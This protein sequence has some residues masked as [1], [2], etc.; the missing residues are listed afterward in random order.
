VSTTIPRSQLEDPNYPSHERNPSRI[1]FARH[2]SI[3][4]CQHSSQDHGW[5]VPTIPVTNAT[6]AA[7]FRKGPLFLISSRSSANQA[8]Q[9]LF[10][11]LFV[12]LFLFLFRFLFV[13]LFLFLFL[14]SPYSQQ[15]VHWCLCFFLR[16]GGCIWTRRGFCRLR[17][18]FL[19][20]L[21][22]TKIRLGIAL[23][24]AGH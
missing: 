8:L 22:R 17:S 3:C 5:K 21:P 20:D 4:N 7:C 10:R 12:L 1:H 14:E 2:T 23:L 9:R 11:F 15:W 19:C 16:G 24:A 13:L 6:Q 18:R